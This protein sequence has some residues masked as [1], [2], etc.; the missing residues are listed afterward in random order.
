MD[1]IRPYSGG[2]SLC[3]LSTTPGQSPTNG[4]GGP[5]RLHLAAL[6]VLQFLDVED[7]PQNLLSASCDG[8]TRSC[9]Q[10]AF[11]LPYFTDTGPLLLSQQQSLGRSSQLLSSPS[12][13]PI[14]GG[15]GQAPRVHMADLVAA[16]PHHYHS[17]DHKLPLHRC[18]LND[19]LLHNPWN[20]TP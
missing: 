4:P 18:S 1:H 8:Q 17:Q 13:N 6:P 12:P 5:G 7:A 10:T 2:R 9:R 14:P 11:P 16:Q 3:R 20:L 15:K 19:L